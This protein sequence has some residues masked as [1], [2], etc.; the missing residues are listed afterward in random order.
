M[1]L[2]RLITAPLDSQARD[3]LYTGQIT[4]ETFASP[5]GEEALFAAD[6]VTWRV[7]KNPVSLY[8][9]GI[10]A[11][12]LEFADPRVRSGVWDHSSFRREP[13]ER[14]KRTGLAAMVT[15]YA[16]RPVAE[17]IIARVNR[18]HEKVRGETPDGMAYHASDPDLLD[19]VQ[20]TAT[21]GFL[22]AYHSYAAT[23]T[24][25]ERDRAY[26]EAQAGGAPYGAKSLPA[27]RAEQAAMFEQRKAVFEPSPIIDDFLE[28]V[29]KARTLP[30]PASLSQ[31]MLVRAAVDLVPE[32]IRE[33]LQLGDRYRLHGWERTMIKA[34]ASMADKMP[35]PSAP[36]AIACKRLGLPVDYLY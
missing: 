31:D 16:A 35:L 4:P 30:A 32:D 10:A 29:R 25:L 7:F 22:E 2:R 20:V 18:M 27:S 12:I 6:S 28:I 3:F 11:V 15:V 17:D 8:I 33:I 13:V 26:S 19:W 36:P 5:A 21:Y 9:G 14:M 34:M 23:L 24:D 1:P